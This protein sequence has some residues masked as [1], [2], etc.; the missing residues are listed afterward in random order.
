MHVD[1]SNLPGALGA[2]KKSLGRDLSE[3]LPQTLEPACT[4]T[5]TCEH[6]KSWCRENNNCE[7][8]GSSSR[9]VGDI[10]KQCVV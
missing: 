1:T 5:E 8:F 3:H 9:I 4:I 7:L 6:P 2:R 10:G